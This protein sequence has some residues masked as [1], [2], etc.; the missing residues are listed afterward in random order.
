[1][2]NRILRP[3]NSLVMSVQ[4]NTVNH[5]TYFLESNWGEETSKGSSF[6]CC[7]SWGAVFLC[8][9]PLVVYKTA[10]TLRHHN[11]G[12]EMT[13]SFLNINRQMKINYR[14]AM[15]VYNVQPNFFWL[16]LWWHCMR[17]LNA[18]KID[19]NWGLGWE[20]FLSLKGRHV[21]LSILL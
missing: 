11:I 15:L 13:V 10:H 19:K 21:P 8:Y 20:T 7:F 18:F 5:P 3:H 14:K 2:G 1:M 9:R 12:C 16:W 6:S 4:H 17:C